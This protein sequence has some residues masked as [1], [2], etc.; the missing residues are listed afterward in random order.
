[1]FEKMVQMISEQLNIDASTIREDSSFKDD[2]GVDSLDLYELVMAM[3]DEFGI[4]IPTE[5]LEGLQT[6]GDVV[7]YL[8][9]KGIEE[10]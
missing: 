8:Q 7:K 5:D 3:E 4:E 2:L 1:M 10:E 9:D 6:V